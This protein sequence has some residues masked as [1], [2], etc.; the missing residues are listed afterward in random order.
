MA[1]THVYRAMEIAPLTV[2]PYKPK[3]QKPSN[4]NIRN[5][6]PKP[7]LRQPSPL[8]IS[9]TVDSGESSAEMPF[10]ESSG[11][12][13]K[14]GD[15]V[16]AARDAVSSGDDEESARGMCADPLFLNYRLSL[17]MSSR[18]DETRKHASGE[19]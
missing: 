6:H 7:S 14:V 10:F 19:I 5:P 9:Q 2:I 12:Q 17:T 11:L 3:L 15:C 16:A 8:N 4:H 18:L 1:S 13:K